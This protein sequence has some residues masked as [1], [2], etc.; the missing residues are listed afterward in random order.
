MEVDFVNSREE[1]GVLGEGWV[2]VAF[3]DGDSLTNSDGENLSSETM[4]SENGIIPVHA[5]LFETVPT[6]PLNSTQL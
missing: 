3:V 1:P 6:M 4:L 5:N 2:G